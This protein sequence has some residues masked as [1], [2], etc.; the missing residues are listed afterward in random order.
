[1]ADVSGYCDST[2]L[3]ELADADILR[4]EADSVVSAYR[5]SPAGGL[6]VLHDPSHPLRREFVGGVGPATRTLAKLD[7]A[8]F[9]RQCS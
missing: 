9:C 6:L 8:A 4:R 3:D 7:V 1:M 5:I 2:L